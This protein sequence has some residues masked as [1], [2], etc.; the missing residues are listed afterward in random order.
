MTPGPT[1]TLLTLSAAA[2][3]RTA[4][5]RLVPAEMT[6]YLL[7]VV[8]LVLFGKAMLAAAPEVSSVIRVVAATWVAYLAAKLWLSSSD[9]GPHSDITLGNVFV[10]TVLNPK[11]LLFGLFLLPS[12]DNVRLGKTVL[13]FVFAIAI[14]STLWICLGALVRGGRAGTVRRVAAVVLCAL[15]ARLFV[16]VMPSLP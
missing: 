8:P 11:A 16:S 3:G 7:V 14:A 6:G 4:A 2:R 1:N 5:F 13:M 15:S 9:R 12:V 10:T